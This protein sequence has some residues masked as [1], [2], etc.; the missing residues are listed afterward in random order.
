MK[1][2][3]FICL[4]VAVTIISSVNGRVVNVKTPTETVEEVKETVVGESQV[5]PSD[6]DDNDDEEKPDQKKL[7]PIPPFIPK[8]P[9]GTKNPPRKICFEF[10]PGDFYDYWRKR[11][12]R[13]PKKNGILS[14]TQEFEDEDGEQ[15]IK[16]KTVQW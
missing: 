10:G 11:F 5:T 1:L 9:P 7:P 6:D 2:V 13:P 12:P 14:R 8:I 16:E 3:V 15:V 4:L